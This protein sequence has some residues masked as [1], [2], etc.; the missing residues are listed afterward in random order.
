MC[1]NANDATP[2]KCSILGMF[3]GICN[4]CTGSAGTYTKYDFDKDGATYHGMVSERL[5]S[6]HHRLQI[7][8]IVNVKVCIK[9]PMIR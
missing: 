9:G 2:R 5:L 1:F 4:N 3:C 8:C 7:D 6:V